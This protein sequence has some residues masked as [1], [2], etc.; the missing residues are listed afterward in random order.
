MD[1]NWLLQQ[2]PFDTFDS[3][4]VEWGVDPEDETTPGWE[5]R[6]L[7]KDDQGGIFIGRFDETPSKA[8]EGLINDLIDQGYIEEGKTYGR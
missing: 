4:I 7:L 6:V 3:F 1:L 2:I 8:V 5:A